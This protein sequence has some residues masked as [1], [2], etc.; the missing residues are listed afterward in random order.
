MPPPQLKSMFWARKAVVIMQGTETQGSH[1]KDGHHSDVS[2]FPPRA[3]GNSAMKASHSSLCASL[4]G[5][6]F[7]LVLKYLP[8]HARA[9][10][11]NTHEHSIKTAKPH[12]LA[13]EKSSKHTGRIF[14]HKLHIAISADNQRMKE[15]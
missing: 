3:Y 8:T 12:A 9:K 4:T 2:Q 6:P 5:T 10:Q 14:L 11:I 1:F 7:C 15:K 13:S